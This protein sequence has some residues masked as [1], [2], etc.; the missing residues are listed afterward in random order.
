MPA[1]LLLPLLPL[2]AAAP[3]RGS[4]P[5][6]GSLRGTSV[7]TGGRPFDVRHDRVELPLA[8]D[9][10][11]EG[12]VGIR[13]APAKALGAVELDASGL[14]VTQVALR[15]GSGA[16]RAVRFTLADGPRSATGRL[17]VRPGRP[18][19]AGAEV[20]FKVHYRGRASAAQ[21]GI[22]QVDEM[23]PGE[24][25]RAFF[26]P[27]Q[28]S[29]PRRLVPYHATPGDAATA[30]LLVVAGAGSRI[31]ASGRLLLDEVFSEPERALLR[32]H[33]VQERAVPVDQLALAVGPF[34]GTVQRSAPARRWR[35]S[36][37]SSS[38][39]SARSVTR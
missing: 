38:W 14:D 3:V 31:L 29:S 5:G 35:P 37:R 36:S 22:F 11:F 28:P 23:P 24:E 1:A 33:W 19:R 16:A 21:E 17:K 18:L 20:T 15:E 32:A 25:T 34:T 30:E 26:A 4:A 8:R 12:T 27:P 39:R 9:G 7:R 2:L 10:R 6:G 13:L